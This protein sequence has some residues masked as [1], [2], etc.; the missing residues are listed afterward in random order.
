MEFVET[1]RRVIIQFRP[2]SLSNMQKS[3]TRDNTGETKLE[4][5]IVTMRSV[6]LNHILR[7]TPNPPADET[8][9]DAVPVEIE[10]NE[11]NSESVST[12]CVKSGSLKFK[13]TLDTS[14][15]I[16]YLCCLD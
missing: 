13:H 16:R 5:M 8:A 3:S 2:S 9:A 15:Q 14:W 11:G 7:G 6:F 4:A 10:W 1:I 12:V